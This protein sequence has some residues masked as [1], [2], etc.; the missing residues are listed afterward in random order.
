[1]HSENPPS[2]PEL[3]DWLARDLVE[4]GYDLRRLVRGLVLSR[5]YAR[6]SRWE[7]GEAPDRSLFA[8]AVVRPLTP[9][10]LAA[11]LQVATAAPASWPSL[12]KTDEFEKR[13]EGVEAAA[14]GFA[15]SIEQPGEHFQ[16]GVGEAL[17]FSNSD[18]VQKQF[19]GD[20]QLIGALKEIK[21]ERAVIDLAVRS[22]YARPPTETE[23]TLLSRFL[24]QRG[25]RPAEACRQ[26]VWALLTSTEFRFNH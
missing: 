19:L 1:M 6:S 14:R 18:R 16:I 25:D 7:S 20:N 24:Q 13:I 3:L 8:V 5:A 22:V 17:L 11:S 15:S 10:Q 12:D 2:H 26:M 23:V 4:H 21:D 9:M